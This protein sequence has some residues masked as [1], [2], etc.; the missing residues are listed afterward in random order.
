MRRN[1]QSRLP[2]TVLAI[3]TRLLTLVYGAGQLGH[4]AR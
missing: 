2:V 1:E 4:A 3:C